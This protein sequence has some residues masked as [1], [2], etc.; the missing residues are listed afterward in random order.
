MLISVY[1][2]MTPGQGIGGGRDTHLY[3]TRVIRYL[4]RVLVSR[5]VKDNTLWEMGGS[6]LERVVLGTVIGV[7]IRFSK[8]FQTKG[9]EEA[10]SY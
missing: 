7:H 6:I 2:G 4:R 3:K 9:N 5:I 10:C 1:L 8:P